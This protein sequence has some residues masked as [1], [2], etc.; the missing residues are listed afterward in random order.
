[1]FDSH[2]CSIFKF[3]HAYILKFVLKQPKLF[4]V[5]VPCESLLERLTFLLIVTYLVHLHVSGIW[6]RQ[7]LLVYP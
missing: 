5:C 2:F 1:M 7:E 4:M 3:Q 6:N